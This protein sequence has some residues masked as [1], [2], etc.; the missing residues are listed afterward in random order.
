MFL[1][2]IKIIFLLCLFLLAES[3]LVLAQDKIDPE[4]Y[5]V[6]AT[7]IEGSIKIDA[8]L[9]EPEWDKAIPVTNFYQLEP[10]EGKIASEQIEVKVLYNQEELY[11]GIKCFDQEPQK[12]VGT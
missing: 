10:E 9:N 8:K 5:K 6:Q 4:A 7:R 1:R 3:F 11:F 2:I 12:I